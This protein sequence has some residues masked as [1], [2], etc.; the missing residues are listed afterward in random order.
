MLLHIWRNQNSRFHPL[1]G[2]LSFV[3][4]KYAFDYWD[5]MALVMAWMNEWAWI[6]DGILTRENWS[7]WRKTCPVATSSTTNCFWRRLGLNMGVCD[8]M[9]LSNCV[10]IVVTSGLVNKSINHMSGYYSLGSIWTVRH[11]TWLVVAWPSFFPC[12]LLCQC[13]GMTIFI[14]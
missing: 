3:L 2:E 11:P 9:L 1:S 6:T 4:L 12:V 10:R 7:T 5:H 13:C 8:E 14:V